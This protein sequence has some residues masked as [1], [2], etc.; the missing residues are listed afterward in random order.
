MLKLDDPMQDLRAH[1]CKVWKLY[2]E[3]GKQAAQ[4]YLQEVIQSQISLS[5]AD[6]ES[7]QVEKLQQILMEERRRREDVQQVASLVSDKLEKTF[8]ESVNEWRPL[9]PVPRDQAA[10]ESSSAGASIIEYDF[11][12]KAPERPARR[13]SGGGLDLAGMIDGMLRDERHL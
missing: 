11:Q 10:N 13:A 5:S 12:S 2:F 8:K 6:V 4:V 3:E 1:F 9:A 7:E